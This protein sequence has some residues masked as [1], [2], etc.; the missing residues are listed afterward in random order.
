MKPVNRPK[1]DKK[2]YITNIREKRAIYGRK[3]SPEFRRAVK[4]IAKKYDKALKR[5]AEK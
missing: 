2:I 1:S 4:A 3:V 5:L